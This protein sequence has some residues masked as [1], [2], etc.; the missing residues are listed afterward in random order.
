MCGVI[1]HISVSYSMTHCT[2]AKYI[3]S[4]FWASEPSLLKTRFSFSNFLYIFLRLQTTAI[5]SFL[6]AERT[7]PRYLK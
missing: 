7:L 1:T 6:T 2:T 3:W 4:E 5:Q